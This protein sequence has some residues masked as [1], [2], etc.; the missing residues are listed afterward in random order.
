[1]Y[2]I[3]VAAARAGVSI[4]VLRAWERRYGV[5]HPERTP[6]GYRLYDEAAIARLRA[7]R[8]LVDQGWSPS[9]AAR[10][11]ADMDEAAFRSLSDAA[12]VAAGPSATASGDLAIQFV[13]AAAAHDGAGVDATLDLMFSQGSFEYVADHYLLPALVSLGAAWESGV[14]DIA[15]EH[16]A[17]HA[18]LRR[19]GSA[20]EAAASNRRRGVVTVVVGLPAGSRHELGALAFSIA[21]RRAGVPVVYEGPDLP[22][23][24]WVAAV[25]QTRARAAVIGVVTGADRPAAAE[26]A[27][28]LRAAH[29]N[30]LIAFGGRAAS[31]MVDGDRSVVLPDGLSQS[32]DALQSA[33]R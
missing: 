2:T 7:M 20:F 15:A 31:G 29:P 18:M 4:A 1:M 12:S 10:S 28:E 25:A 23:E 17:S 16:A 9:T 27:R 14:L 22:A 8:H 30:I 32:V 6:A 11:L 5:V 3:K 21:A 24:D 33:L 26:V 19:M 13:E